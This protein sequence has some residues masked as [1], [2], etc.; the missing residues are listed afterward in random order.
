MP[1][2]A[3]SK[4]ILSPY[5]RV[6]ATTAEALERSTRVAH[7]DSETAGEE[8]AVLHAELLPIM[9]TR[10]SH[11]YG[12]RVFAHKATAKQVSRVTTA[13]DAAKAISKKR[14]GRFYAQNKIQIAPT[15]SLLSCRLLQLRSTLK[16]PERDTTPNCS[17]PATAGDFPLL[18]R[19]R[20]RIR[21]TPN[22]VPVAEPLQCS[23]Q[24]QVRKAES[25]TC[26][27]LDVAVPPFVSD[28]VSS[29]PSLPLVC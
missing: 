10:V 4:G 26:A 14:K 3:A 19:V 27:L 28:V 29:A 23:D 11:T 13:I 20:L 16:E 6:R 17:A 9:L 24:L 8:T 21:P 25:F 18:W 5:R 12:T 22:E 7:G 15:M 1:V 2:Q